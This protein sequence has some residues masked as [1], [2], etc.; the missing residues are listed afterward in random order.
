MATT[1]A[2]LNSKNAQMIAV[3]LESFLVGIFAALISFVV[4]IMW[5]GFNS[6][7]KIHKVL[8]GATIV[9][10]ILSVI[11]LGLVMQEVTVESVSLAC[12]Q[13]QIVLSMIQYVTGDLVLIWR[14]WVILG[15]NYV[16]ASGP[17]ILMIVAAAFED[18][19]DTFFT[20]VSV[21]LIVTNTTLC[22]FLITSRIW[23][24]QRIPKSVSSGTISPWTPNHYKRITILVVESG[25]LYTSCQIVSLVLHYTQ[26][27][28]LPIILDLEIPLIGILP[29]LIIVFVHF[30][31]VSGS[32]NS[33]T[34]IPRPVIYKGASHAKTDVTRLSL[35]GNVPPGELRHT[36]DNFSSLGY[37]P[38][39]LPK[40]REYIHKEV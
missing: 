35:S 9:M 13:L 8:F 34:S 12:A 37:P 19:A 6:M 16:I 20:A 39:F 5:T 24:M 29:T 30:G 18:H 11:H 22:T 14:V 32:P 38:T 23:Y 10:F 3:M 28:A 17:L 26:S 40:A 25:A 33:S 15:R 7:S 1:K 31:V 36:D 2:F 4:W 27:V 21:S